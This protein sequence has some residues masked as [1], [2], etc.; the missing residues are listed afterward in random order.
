MKDAEESTGGEQHEQTP[1]RVGGEDN[2]WT[3]IGVVPE[4]GGGEFNKL[5]YVW[6]I[7]VHRHG[8]LRKRFVRLSEIPTEEI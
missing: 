4:A 1:T 3:P 6:V 8:N 2:P 5:D 7:E